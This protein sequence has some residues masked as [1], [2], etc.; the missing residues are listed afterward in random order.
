MA[1]VQVCQ[2]ACTYVD[3]FQVCHVRNSFPVCLASHSFS[4]DFLFA[5]VMALNVYLFIYSNEQDDPANLSWMRRFSSNF[6]M[7][8]EIL[9]T[10]QND[11]N[12]QANK[13][14]QKTKRN[15]T[16]ETSDVLE[17]KNNPASNHLNIGDDIA[18]RCLCTF[19]N[20]DKQS[21]RI[22]KSGK[23]E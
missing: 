16:K 14:S 5:C 12:K 19:H 1:N 18:E 7:K 10:Q 8:R 11:K 13:R 6:Y 2:P 15:K 21:Y 23:K 9:C 22:Q 17:R 4:S 20:F 3:F